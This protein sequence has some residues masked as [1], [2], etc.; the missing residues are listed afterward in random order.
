MQEAGN[1]ACNKTQN[2]MDKVT[3]NFVVFNDET[4]NAYF[5]EKADALR[6]AKDGE[7][8]LP[9]PCPISVEF[10]RRDPFVCTVTGDR[11]RTAA[12]CIGIMW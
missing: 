3:F 9:L 5:V 12:E 10:N 4:D 2:K 6:Y 8:V 11:A 7:E 1:D